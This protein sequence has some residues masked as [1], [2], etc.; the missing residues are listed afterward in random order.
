MAKFNSSRNVNAMH[1]GSSTSSLMTMTMTRPV[2]SSP[3]SNKKRPKTREN[4]LLFEDPAHL[5]E[6]KTFNFPYVF[7]NLFPVFL[8]TNFTLDSDLL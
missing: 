6:N 5:G 7:Q 3:G 1:A 2:Q 4:K 8:A